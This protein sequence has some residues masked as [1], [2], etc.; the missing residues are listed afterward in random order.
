MSLHKKLA[1]LKPMVKGLNKRQLKA[2]D[3]FI[4]ELLAEKVEVLEERQ[5][6]KGTFRLQ[7]V[8]CGK[9]GCKCAV[10]QLHGPYWYRF[11]SEGSRTRSEYVGKIL[12]ER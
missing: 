9:K 2:L 8:R 12:N 11:W 1:E 5:T 7:R 10:G 3:A 6:P 4:H